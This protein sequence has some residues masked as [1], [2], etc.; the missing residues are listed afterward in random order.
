MKNLIAEVMA[1]CA[2]S[3]EKRIFGVKCQETSLYVNLSG[4]IK[5]VELKDFVV[6]F[7]VFHV[8]LIDL[9]RQTLV[10]N[11]TTAAEVLTVLNLFKKT[12]M[13]LPVIQEILTDYLHEKEIQ[14]VRLS[15]VNPDDVLMLLGEDYAFANN[16]KNL[17]KKYYANV[18]FLWKGQSLDDEKLLAVIN[19]ISPLAKLLFTV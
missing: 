2:T 7:N 9:L 5:A 19:Q 18:S 13:S 14:P 10:Y 6:N 15:E 12:K 16:E 17:V 4:L 3:D 11:F 1:A 8:Q